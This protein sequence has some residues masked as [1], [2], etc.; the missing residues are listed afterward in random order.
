MSFS[1]A[2]HMQTPL[3]ETAPGITLRDL[4]CLIKP[5]DLL[6]I[7][8]PNLYV[9]AKWLI[10]GKLNNY[11]FFFLWTPLINHKIK[12]LIGF[13]G[14]WMSADMQPPTDENTTH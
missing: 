13:M 14:L 5:N 1:Q 2:S 12:Q 7:V 4:R 10:H 8:A 9:I 6:I 3:S 11:L